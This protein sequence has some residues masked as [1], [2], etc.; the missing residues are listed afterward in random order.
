VDNK[1]LEIARQCLEGAESGTMTFPQVVGTLMAAAFDGYQIDLR[2]GL[3]AYYLQDGEGFQLP[4]H[5]SEVAVATEF[6]VDVVKATIR[7][8][9]ALVPGYTYNGFC[10]KVKRAGCAGYQ[11]SLQGRRVLYFGRTGETHTEYF[12]ETHT[13]SQPPALGCRQPIRLRNPLEP[14]PCPCIAVGFT[15]RRDSSHR[16]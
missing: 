14:S 15:V 2:L 4:T 16:Y 6:N 8:A 13:G 1:N 10:D 7:E 12:P 3:A 5:T 9:Q 11:V